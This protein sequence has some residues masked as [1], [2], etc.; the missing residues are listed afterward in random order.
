MGDITNMQTMLK[1]LE[2][3]KTKQPN[4]KRGVKERNK[5]LQ[6][7]DKYLLKNIHKPEINSSSPIPLNQ[8][9]PNKNNENCQLTTSCHYSES[10]D[11]Q[12]NSP[13]RKSKLKLDGFESSL[14]LT[15][16]DCDESGLDLSDIVNNIVNKP[17]IIALE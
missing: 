12:I 15:A 5:G 4:K 17:C 2:I 3:N 14:S 9:T 8:S 10:D 1:R 7:L 6:T 13:L 16:Y 11:E